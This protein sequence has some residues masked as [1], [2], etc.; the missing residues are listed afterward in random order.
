MDRN[1]MSNFYNGPSVDGFC[2]VSFQ[3]TK[4]FQMIRFLEIDQSETRIACVTML[5]SESGRNEQSIQRTSNKYFLPSF[6]SFG[7]AVSK[8]IL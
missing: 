1:E 2:Q 6:G 7:Q 8:K 5:V 4:R 3:L